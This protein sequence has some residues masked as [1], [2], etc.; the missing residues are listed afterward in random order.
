MQFDAAIDP[1]IGQRKAPGSRVAGFANV[2]VFPDLDA[3]N[4]G[5]KIAERLGGF[6]AIGSFVLGLSKP[7][8]DL[9]RG[10]SSQDVVDA[11]EA[12][13]RMAAEKVST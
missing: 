10:C 7:W 3:G 11:A 12:A 5:Y 1:E 2:L 8:V 13:A 6:K 4:T 9:S